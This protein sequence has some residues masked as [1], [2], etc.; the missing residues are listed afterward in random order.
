MHQLQV[1]TERQKADEERKNNIQ[2]AAIAIG[3]ILFISLFL[4]LSRS[5][6][7]NEKWISFLGVLGLL[8]LFE[9][10]NL[11]LHPYLDKLTGH[12]PVLMLV[13][14]VAIASLLIPF[15]H[16]LEHWV[17]NKMVEK[18]KQVRLA[19]AKKT[20]ERLEGKDT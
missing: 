12:S 2:Y 19:A 6:I 5:I 18:N 11:F 10:I 8:V 13:I 14:L 4:L 20:I 9:F 16:R 7:V 1:K 15:H 3:I 17:K